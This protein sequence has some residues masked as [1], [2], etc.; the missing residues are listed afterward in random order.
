M[1]F[2]KASHAAILTCSPT[3]C[4]DFNITDVTSANEQITVA[5]KLANFQDSTVYSLSF[6]QPQKLYYV[7]T[8]VF[9]IFP[10]IES[11]IIF[12]VSLNHLVSNAFINAGNLNGLHINENNFPDLPD[13]FCSSCIN[14]T[15]LNLMNN[16]IVNVDSNAF[17]GLKFLTTVILQGNK[18][19]CIPPGLFQNTPLIDLI[20]LSNNEITRL[21]RLTFKGLPNLYDI[22]LGSNKIAS[23]PNFDTTLTGIYT[24][25][26]MSLGN[27]PIMAIHPQFLTHFF[28]SG[29]GYKSTW[30]YFE[31]SSR[32]TTCFP[33][34]IEYT[35]IIYWSWM[36]INI[37]IDDC[38][39]NWTPELEFSPVSCASPMTTTTIEK[40][41]RK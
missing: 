3:T 8:G 31:S 1:L 36:K 33:Q 7:P 37:S 24:G 21:D 5:G 12:N 2:I 20:D 10:N 39:A 9:S 25:T 4:D 6:T 40:N 13:S 27:N 32:N 19:S 22:L 26:S 34:N 38:Y 28:T 16:N 15:Y 35:S 41:R 18:I 29:F 30:L 23:I 11:V 14:V 17:K